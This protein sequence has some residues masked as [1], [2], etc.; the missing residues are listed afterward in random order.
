MIA[1]IHAP[2]DAATA[3]AVADSLPKAK[4]N[5]PPI[6]VLV[7]S[8]A[9]ARAATTDTPLR[10]DVYAALDRGAHIIPLLLTDAPLVPLIAHLLPLD[11]RGGLDLPLLQA[12]IDQILEAGSTPMRVLTPKKRLSNAR[13]GLVML[14]LVAVMFV[15]G[16]ILIAVM[17][18][19]RPQ[20]EYLNLETEFA[21]TRQSYVI[22]VVDPLLPRSTQDAENFAPTAAAVGTR[23]RSFLIETATAISQ[24]PQPPTPLPT[25]A[26]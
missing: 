1:V 3:A 15:Y 12:R 26:P 8:D 4:P 13:V 20:T 9:A 11:F 23:F 25:S 24:Q 17:G 21:V 6:T 16:V 22:P 19:R 7:W 18:V 10:R 14:F 5:Q 2:E